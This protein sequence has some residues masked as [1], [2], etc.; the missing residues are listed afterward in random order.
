MSSILPTND[1]STVSGTPEG[2]HGV[3]PSTRSC[4]PR[5]L[6]RTSS[7]LT[8]HLVEVF[9]CDLSGFLSGSEVANGLLMWW[10]LSFFTG[11]QG[12]LTFI[13]GKKEEKMGLWSW[14]PKSEFKSEFSLFLNTTL[15]YGVV[16][17]RCLISYY[18]KIPLLQ[19]MVSLLKPF[20]MYVV[21][22]HYPKR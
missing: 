3:L 2:P 12:S 5:P 13:K 1:L 4:P 22:I 18:V 20:Y 7:T 11:V 19:V 8:L 10:T 21:F 15:V 6:L 14:C 17:R 9:W 16:I